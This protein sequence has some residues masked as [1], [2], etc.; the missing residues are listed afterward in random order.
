[1]GLQLRVARGLKPHLRR[2]TTI[3]SPLEDD[4]QEVSGG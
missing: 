3:A 2:N 1:M 4:E